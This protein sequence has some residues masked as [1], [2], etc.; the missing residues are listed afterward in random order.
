MTRIFNSF[1][2]D[3]ELRTNAIQGFDIQYGMDFSLTCKHK[4]ALCQLIFPAVAV[5]HNLPGQW[6]IDNNNGGGEMADLIF[7]GSE[8]GV[9]KDIPT[10]IVRWNTGIHITT[11]SIFMVDIPKKSLFKNGITFGYSIDT[12]AQNPITIFSDIGKTKLKDI[13]KR[14]INQRFRYV[15][16]V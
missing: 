12:N 11:F 7:K 6:N 2:L 13:Q 4:Y 8:N 15:K 9:I 16:I 1:V 3:Y 14:L 10:E 5:G